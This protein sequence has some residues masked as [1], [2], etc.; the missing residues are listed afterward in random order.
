M[1]RLADWLLGRPAQEPAR[2]LALED[3]ED[4]WPILPRHVMECRDDAAELLIVGEFQD[5]LECGLEGGLQLLEG[6][7]DSRI[8]LLGHDG[9]E[10]LH[11]TVDPCQWNSHQS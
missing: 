4:D 9:E 3:A 6:L 7:G 1:G 5:E 8:R 11:R 2:D 10:T